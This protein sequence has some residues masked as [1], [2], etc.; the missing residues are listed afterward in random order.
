MEQIDLTTPITQPSTT[1]YRL[2]KLDLRWLDQ[3]IRI[4]LVADS[5]EVIEHSYDGDVARNL[6]IALNK[7]DLSTNSLQ[8]RVLNKLISDGVITGTISGVPD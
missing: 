4:E 8:R 1:N 6:M 5:G 3:H 7:A 2:N